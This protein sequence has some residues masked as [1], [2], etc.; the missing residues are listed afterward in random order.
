MSIVI[1]TFRLKANVKFFE[2]KKFFR[3]QMLELGHMKGNQYCYKFDF[4]EFSNRKM[5][6]SKRE[7]FNIVDMRHGMKLRFCTRRIWWKLNLI[8]CVRSIN[9]LPFINFIH[10]STRTNDNV[11]PFIQQIIELMSEQDMMMTMI[12]SCLNY[13]NDFSQK[14]NIQKWS[15][16]RRRRKKISC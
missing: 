10:L 2:K 14:R 4:M 3:F 16:M 13:A 1:D 11:V 15:W 12:K 7:N 9:W 8:S 5:L 6:L